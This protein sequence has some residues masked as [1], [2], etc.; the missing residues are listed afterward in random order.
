MLQI[1]DTSRTNILPENSLASRLNYRIKLLKGGINS[2]SFVELGSG[3]ELQKEFI[4]IEVPAGQ[5]NYTWNDYNEN[6]IKELNEFEIAAFSDQ[7][8]YMGVYTPNNSY[9]KIYNFQYNQNLNIDFRKIVKGN[10]LTEKFLNKFYN[11]TALNTQKKTNDLDIK[12]LVNPLVNSDN[13]IIQQLSNSLRNSLFFNR[14]NSKYS[15]ELVTQLFANKNLLINGTDFRSSNKDQLK[16][17][18]NLNRSFMLNSQ[19]SKELKSNASTYMQNRN[20]NIENK[21]IFNRLSFQPN[22]MFRIA[23][24]ARYSEK[25]ND[26]EYGNEK[27][28]L[29]DL[30]IE[31]RESKRD[32]GLFNAELHFVNINY[33][34]ESNSTIGFEMLEGLQPG[35]NVTWKISFQK[36]MSNNIQFSLSYNGRKSEENRAI[37]TGSMQMR[38]FF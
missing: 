35:S 33:N 14:S 38:A 13:P 30:G 3:L 27:A 29:K 2:N 26:V 21:E 19:V 5:G 37:H 23:V 12:T 18:W 24:N 16:L 32:K 1:L 20:F 4:Y 8:S 11:Q 22:T 31:L 7:A 36:K 9:I 15:L 10:T 28:F 6:D 34:G 17:R 25:S